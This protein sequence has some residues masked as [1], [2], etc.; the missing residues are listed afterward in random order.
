[1]LFPSNTILVEVSRKSVDEMLAV[2]LFQWM[3]ADMPKLRM[4]ELILNIVISDEKILI[5]HISL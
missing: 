2:H 5:H 4:L 1:M 3:E